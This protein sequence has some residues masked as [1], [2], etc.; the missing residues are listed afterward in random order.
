MRRTAL[1]LL[2]FAVPLPVTASHGWAGFDLCAI[3]KDKLPP[4]LSIELL[5]DPLSPGAA[6]LNQYCTQCHNLPGPDRHTAA[7]WHKVVSK[8]H[9]LMDVSHQFGGLM[10]RVDT[11]QDEQQ[12][13]LLTY[14]QRHSATRNRSQSADHNSIPSPSSQDFAPGSG[15]LD[16][17]SRPESLWLKRLLPLTP[18]L[19]LIGLGLFRWNRQYRQTLVREEHSCTTD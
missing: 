4:G 19:L 13:T 9:V 6:L 18:F 17:T 11:M 15:E 5:P 3:H 7:D 10:G 16:E 2:V 1:L 14:L 8:M 12:K